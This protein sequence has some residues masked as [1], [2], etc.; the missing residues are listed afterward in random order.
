MLAAGDGFVTERLQP[1]FPAAIRSWRHGCSLI[2]RPHD[3]AFSV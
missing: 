1:V 2:M 3:A